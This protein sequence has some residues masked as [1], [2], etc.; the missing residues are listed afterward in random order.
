ML[1]ID[2]IQLC[3]CFILG[4][5]GDVGTE[6]KT[7]RGIEGQTITL[8]T[9]L[10]GLQNDSI[11]WT[12]GPV[13]AQTRIATL[14]VGRNIPEYNERL[15]LDAQ[16]GS[17]TI[18]SLTT[19]DNGIYELTVLR[20]QV[21]KQ[22]FKLTIYAPV[23][24]PYIR[25][26]TQSRSL[27]SPLKQESCSVVCTVKNGRDVTLSWYRGEERIN[28]TINPDTN[29][30]LFLPLEVNEGNDIYSCVA[31]NPV[32]DQTI[33]LSIEEHCQPDSGS[34][35]PHTNT[36]KYILPGVP[37]AAAFMTVIGLLVWIY[38]KKRKLKHQESTSVIY[39]D[40]QPAQK[41]STSQLRGND[42]VDCS[43]HSVQDDRTIYSDLHV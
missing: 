19:S 25:P 10:T 27:A 28:Q 12:Y 8:N 17:L 36:Y 24:A 35:V 40:V 32:S 31:N 2:L 29:K 4:V 18:R 6:I 9:G 5:L 26:Q 34:T 37:I 16:S 3:I 14:N 42:Q 13:R 43:V 39:A 22:T 11:Y 33:K 20:E 23:S 7:V 21:L 41:M 38:W 15:N 30:T 1:A